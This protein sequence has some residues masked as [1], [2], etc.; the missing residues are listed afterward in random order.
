MTH[1]SP[2]YG[3]ALTLAAEAHAGQVRK[4]ANSPYIHHPVAVSALV[5]EHGG[6]EDQ[7]IAGLLHDVLEDC[8]PKY[9]QRIM[10]EFGQPVY[11]IVAHLTDGSTDPFVRGQ[12]DWR[13]RKEAYLEHLVRAPDVVILVS[14][15]DKLH[16]AL[17]IADD[18]AD[19]G[20]AVFDRFSKP[21]AD[22]TWY[23]RSLQE[24]LGDRLGRGHK[25]A[26]RLAAAIDSW[27]A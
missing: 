7:A 25:L 23:Y 15:S 24:V 11:E 2:R 13:V 22:T 27:A 4:G 1:F 26:K 12:M 18:Y 14:A 20:A 10:E 5:I 17:S 19:M 21:R 8:D 16:N 9:G 6:T 3:A